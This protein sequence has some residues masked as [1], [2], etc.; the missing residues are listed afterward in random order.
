MELT[1][2]IGVGNPLA[3]AI[4]CLEVTSAN[5]A[6]VYLYWLEILAGMKDTLEGCYLPDEVCGHF[7][8]LSLERILCRQPNQCTFICHE[9]HFTLAYSDVS[10]VFHPFWS[11]INI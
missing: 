1:Q 10:D 7:F 3:H 5:L 11:A 2:F 9:P 4:E 8:K 6:D